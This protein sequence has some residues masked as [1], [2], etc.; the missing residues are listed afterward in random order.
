V[1]TDLTVRLAV[2]GDVTA[3]G[4]RVPPD[5]LTI[6]AGRA[7]VTRPL[8]SPAPG[9][10]AR[11]TVA[12]EPTAGWRIQPDAAAIEWLVGERSELFAFGA[13]ETVVLADDLSTVG[14]WGMVSG[15]GRFVE[16]V[17]GPA[18]ESNGAGFR[19]W[20]ALPLAVD[21]RQ[22]PIV[23]YLRARTPGGDYGGH[24]AVSLPGHWLGLRVFGAQGAAM[25][26]HQNPRGESTNAE[27]WR[28]QGLSREAAAG[29]LDYR[30]EV[31]LV[32]GQPE[33]ALAVWEPAKGWVDHGRGRL[34]R[35]SALGLLIPPA[36]DRIELTGRNG[37]AGFIDAVAIA[38]GQPLSDR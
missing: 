2:S 19:A 33:G 16:G 20:R 26:G 28:G 35:G 11:L 27:L 31:R 14:P 24:V 12:L 30:L 32:D 8:S 1:D 9:R 25:L 7:A 38:V 3:V 21:L 4:R 17:L 23:F 22:R 37:T 18:V 5:R 36:L 13:K 15:S 29:W 6:P 34:P 10:F